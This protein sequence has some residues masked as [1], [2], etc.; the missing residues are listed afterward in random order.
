M[1][2]SDV[3]VLGV[4][5]VP[6][7]TAPAQARHETAPENEDVV[8]E[9]VDRLRT[10]GATTT[11]KLVYTHNRREEIDRIAKAEASDVILVPHHAE[12]MEWILVQLRGDVNVEQITG[13]V[14]G[15]PNDTL[16]HVQLLHAADS[17]LDQ[18][19]G[20]A[21]LA[22]AREQLRESGID[23]QVIDAELVESD[24]AVGTIIERAKNYDAIVMG[25][26]KPSLMDYIFGDVPHR[27]SQAS[28]CPVFVVPP[29]S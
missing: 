7:Q 23:E 12:R 16:G 18:P 4:C 25:G 11:S 13:V 20:E 17:E 29:K 28:G 10:A 14:G 1:T 19:I 21:L 22:M 8:G 5:T 3:H 27:I 9:I 24:D 6:D 15:F 26:N 2:D